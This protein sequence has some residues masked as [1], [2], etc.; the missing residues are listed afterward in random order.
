MNPV[1]K[2]IK[3]L[4]TQGFEYFGKYYS[5]Y[6]A[7]VY[8]AADPNNA[9]R[10]RLVIP[11]ITGDKPMA[12][13]A[14][15]RNQYSGDGYGMQCT[16]QPGDMVWVEFEQGN[17]RFPVWSYGYFA[18][19]KKPEELRDL[20]K[21]WFKT[22]KGTILQA[23]DNDEGFASIKYY[24]GLEIKIDKDGIYLIRDSKKIS[25][26]QSPN[27]NEPAVLGNKNKEVLDDLKSL[28]TNYNTDITTFATTQAAVSVG[29]LAGYAAG[30]SALITAMQLHQ[31]TLAALVQKIENT[32]SSNITLD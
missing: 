14:Y 18:K 19:N 16:P 2:F 28:L 21:Y 32:K 10:L 12:T 24:K 22:P 15:P 26:G 31:T 27:S 7:F 11:H 29:P 1:V 6:R 30:Y 25:L 5:C 13:W 8:D 3:D 4:T 9:S 17:P 23:D 20:K